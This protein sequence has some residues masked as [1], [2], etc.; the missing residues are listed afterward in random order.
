[1][2]VE[3]AIVFCGSGDMPCLMAKEGEALFVELTLDLVK[4]DAC[5]LDGTKDILKPT[6]MFPLGPPNN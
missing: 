2:G 4:S 5:F 3:V 1:M 6:V